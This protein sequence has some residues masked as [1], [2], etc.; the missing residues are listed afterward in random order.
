MNESK[1]TGLQ[2]KSKRQNHLRNIVALGIEGS[3]GERPNPILVPTS[4]LKFASKAPQRMGIMILR[5]LNNHFSLADYP[6]D[7]LP[8]CSSPSEICTHFAMAHGP[9]ANGGKRYTVVQILLRPEQRRALDPY[10]PLK[11]AHSYLK[12][13]ITISNIR[14]SNVTLA[15]GMA[16]S[17]N[18]FRPLSR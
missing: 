5:D 1:D 16:T 14:R 7:V 2:P 10:R 11:C 4:Q 12:C 8:P 15:G 3:S 9:L 17:N 13:N 18:I 6:L